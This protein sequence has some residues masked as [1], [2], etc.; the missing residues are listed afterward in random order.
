MSVGKYDIT[1]LRQRQS[2]LQRKRGGGDKGKIFPAHAI[3]TYGGCRGKMEESNPFHVPVD[4]P[5]GKNSGLHKTGGWVGSRD[6]LKE[7]KFLPFAKI[8]GPDR[9]GHSQSVY[10]YAISAPEKK[11]L[12]YFR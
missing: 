11:F 8:R 4:L 2:L 10:P 9:T 7:R 1:L 12:H 6:S 5:S 3:K